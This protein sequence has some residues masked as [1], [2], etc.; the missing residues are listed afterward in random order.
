MNE[1]REISDEVRAL[2]GMMPT[3]LADLERYR[4]NH[5]FLLIL[6]C[7]FAELLVSV[8]IAEKCKHATEINERNQDYPFAVRLTLLHE[9]GIIPDAHYT[10]L[11][12]L[13]RQRNDA[14]HRADF[15]FTTER[16]PEWG[17]PDHTTPEKLF[18]LCVN[19]LGG[20]WNGHV[21]LFREKLPLGA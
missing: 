3:V 6:S 10:W 5:R 2:G 21:E 17:G 16:L 8:L 4:S 14:A 18:S 12:W 7:A 15:R 13:R 9:L 11:S 19:I 20:F 1:I